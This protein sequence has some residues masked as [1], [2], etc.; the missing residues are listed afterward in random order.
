MFVHI[1]VM[2]YAIQ[3]NSVVEGADVTLPNDALILYEDLVVPLSVMYVLALPPKCIVQW[4]GEHKRFK[5]FDDQVMIEYTL[6]Y[7]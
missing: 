7:M 6:L 2:L 4:D 3:F 1:D 5:R